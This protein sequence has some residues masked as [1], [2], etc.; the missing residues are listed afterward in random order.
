MLLFDGGLAV[1]AFAV[2][3]FCIIDVITTPPDQCRNLPKL[4]WLLVVVLLIDVGSI[5]WLI[6][7]RNW[8]RVPFGAAP[9][10]ARR[11]P[12]RPTN[13]DDDE[14]FLAGLR[15]RAEEQRRRARETQQRDDSP[16]DQ[17]SSG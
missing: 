13:P 4:A 11:T 9:Q 6:A 14:D 2:W 7:G 10:D 8:A 15:A 1:I 5:V 12:S 17:P 16:G 3:V